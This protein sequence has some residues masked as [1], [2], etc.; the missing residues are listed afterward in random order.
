ML[1]ATVSNREDGNDKSSLADVEQC[2]ERRVVATALR[3]W[4]AQSE[5]RWGRGLTLRVRLLLHE[6]NVTLASHHHLVAVGVDA[7][8]CG[9]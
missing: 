5:N 2:I 1:G 8:S 9:S 3:S 7:D 6:A 4:W